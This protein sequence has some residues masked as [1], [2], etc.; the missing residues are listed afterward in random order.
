MRWCTFAILSFSLSAL[1]QSRPDNTAAGYTASYSQH[2]PTAALE[3]L[4]AQE[5]DYEMEQR[6]EEA[7][8]LGD[9][10]WNTRWDDNSPEAHSTRNSHNIALLEKLAKMDRATLPASQQLNFDL[11]KK[12]VEDR[13]VRY[14]SRWFLMAFNQREGIQTKGDLAGSLNFA[15]VKDYDDWLARLN[16]FPAAM[17]GSIALL[18]MGIKEKMVHPKVIMQRIPVQIDRQI[19]SDPTQSGFYAPFRKFPTA[20][21]PAEQQRLQ[22]AGRK[23]VEEKI[24]PAF[25][26]FKEFFASEYLPACYEQVG[27]WQLPHSDQLYAYLIKHYTTTILTAEQIHEIGLKEVARINADMAVVMRKTGFKG[28]REEFYKFLR[29]DPQ[30]FYK[31]PEDLLNGY[32]A[33]AKTIDPNLVKV[34]R[35]LPRLPYGVKPIPD[36]SAPDTTA[37]YY[38]QGAADGTRAGTYFVNLYQPESRPK[39]E[40]MALTLHESVP[41]HHLQIAR[42]HELGAQPKFRR[43]GEYTAYVEGWALY[44]ESLGEE[45][46]L[47]DD[48][49]SK[50]GQLTYQMWRAVRLVIDTGIHTKHWTRDQAIQYFMDNAPKAEL[51]IVNEV[52]R[53]IAW[54]GQ[55]LAYKIGELKIKELRTRSQEKLGANFDLKGFHDVVL[56]SGP[57]PLDLLEK[58]VDAWVSQMKAD[59]KK[60]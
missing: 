18:R 50:F 43:F 20:I 46:G 39:W 55:A 17:D 45:M 11:F 58:N 59:Q 51:D 60:K 35:T 22:Q 14:Q 25:R 49:Y 4:F 56:G 3:N 7:S 33:V 6:P 41:G 47:Y 34:F 13:V 54:P 48:P 32:K 27:A 26:K 28:T 42:A 23:A 29:T 31:T 8:E 24:V 57:V 1:S 16:A 19:V 5:W 38:S 40:M 53:Y 44:G 36:V 30:F 15:T 37:A 21:P 52:D 2:A 9:L 10:R 12:R